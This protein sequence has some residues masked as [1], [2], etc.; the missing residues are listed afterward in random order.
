MRSTDRQITETETAGEG[1]GETGAK[2]AG[3][4]K[5]V[6]SMAIRFRGEETPS[7]SLTHSFVHCITRSFKSIDRS[8][9]GMNELPGGV[10]S[11]CGVV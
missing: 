1:E 10:C 3:E 9:L 8:K 7:Q 4:Q 6:V 11:V 5:I 2:R